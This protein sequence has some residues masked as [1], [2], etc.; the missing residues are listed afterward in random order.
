[1][2]P[3]LPWKLQ[4]ARAQTRRQFLKTSQAGLGTIALRY[5]PGS[6]RASA[7][8]VRANSQSGMPRCQRRLDR[9]PD[10]SPGR[11]TSRRRP[12]ESS[13]CICR[14]GLLSKTCS[15][16]SP[17]WS[18]I[19]LQP[20]PDELL[21]NQKFAFIKGHPKLLGSPYRFQKCGQSGAMVSELLPHLARR[22]RRHR[23]HQVDVYRSV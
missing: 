14:E 7:W 18:S 17:S 16:T 12:S 21:K 22:G 5:A 2:D 4:L 15:I 13:T 9:Q 10:D 3:D 8:P 23:D 11:L 20:C 6:Q 1:M 19:T